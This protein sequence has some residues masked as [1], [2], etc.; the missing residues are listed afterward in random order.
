MKTKYEHIEFIKLS[1]GGVG[2]YECLNK[3]DHSLG[4]I[5]FHRHFEWSF[6]ATDICQSNELRDIADFMQQLKELG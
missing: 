4:L 1:K 5:I 2:E 6:E 3:H